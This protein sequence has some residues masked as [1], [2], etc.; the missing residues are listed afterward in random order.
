MTKYSQFVKLLKVNFICRYVCR[1]KP[2][3]IVIFHTA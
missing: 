1:V 2:T 3:K